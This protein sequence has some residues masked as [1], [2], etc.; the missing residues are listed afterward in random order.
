MPIIV[1]SP[2]PSS[3]NFV[4]SSATTMSPPKA[5]ALSSNGNP[6]F[7]AILSREQGGQRH[8][9]LVHSQRELTEHL[10]AVS[11]SDRRKIKNEDDRNINVDIDEINEE[12]KHLLFGRE[13]QNNNNKQ[14]HKFR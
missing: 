5:S 14:G 2:L 13:N 1:P 7:P 3:E 10:N 9:V 4:I 6:V 11:T 8:K 12:K